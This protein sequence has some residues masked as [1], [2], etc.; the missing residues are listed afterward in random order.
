MTVKAY[1]LGLPRRSIAWQ[2]MQRLI[3]VLHEKIGIPCPVATPD[4]CEFGVL[5][6]YSVINMSVSSSSRRVY[7]SKPCS[8]PPPLGLGIAATKVSKVVCISGSLKRRISFF[9]QL[10]ALPDRESRWTPERTE[11]LGM[12]R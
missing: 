12:D 1:S 8:D 9:C 4:R 2:G 3:L 6:G 7:E 5:W 11:P 10:L